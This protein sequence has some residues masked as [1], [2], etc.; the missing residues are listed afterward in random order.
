MRLNFIINAGDRI[1]RKIKYGFILLCYPLRVEVV[2]SDDIIHDGTINIFYGNTFPSGS[3]MKQS[4]PMFIKSSDDFVECIENSKPPEI[5]DTEWFD[6]NN[7]RLP[8]LFPTVDSSINFDIAA[9]IFILASEFQDL[10]SHERDEF[11]RLRAMDSLQDKLGILEFP[12]VNYYSLF[13]KKEIERKFNVKIE[14]KKYDEAEFALALTH[15]ID[16]TSSLNPRMIKRNFFGHALLNRERLPLDQ[17][18]I[19]LFYPMLAVVG[20]NP[21]KKGLKFLKNI[22][23]SKGIKSTFFIKAGSTAKQD[24]KYSLDSRTFQNFVN[25]LIDYGF[26]IGIH[27][28]MKTYIDSEQFA[29]EKRRLERMIGAKIVSVRQ[30]YLKFTAGET[31]AVWEEADMKYDSTL[32]F[33]RKAGFRNSVAFP[34]PL[35]N[36]KRDDISRIVELPLIIMDGTFAEDKT[37]SATETFQKMKML[38]NETKMAHGSASILFHNSI[39]DPIDFPGYGNIYD[40]LL[41]EAENEGFKMD[42]LSNV[43]E[44][45]R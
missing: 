11:D 7:K 23:I 1:R 30:H 20:Y 35:Y 29:S 8:R 2:F 36:F 40:K 12:V 44:N 42:S 39:V 21:P 13:F 15:D 18:I 34:F 37:M 16:Y 43:I 14:L 19:K 28:S 45:F 24:I 5:S 6:F 25:S 3:P 41:T 10:I 31:V 38:I 17:R 33:S 22:E 9:A 4:N 32:G 26:E 27:P